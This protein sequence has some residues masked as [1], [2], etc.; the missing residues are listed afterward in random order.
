MLRRLTTFIALLAA[1]VPQAVV[2][3][4]FCTAVGPSFAERRAECDALVVGEAGGEAGG[5][6]R[7]LVHQVWK[8]ADAFAVGT[9]IETDTKNDVATGSTALLIGRHGDAWTWDVL[10]V[11]ESSLAY[12]ARLPTLDRPLADRLRYCAK[13]LESD[14]PRV[15]D[16]AYREFGR[17]PLDAVALTSDAFDYAQVREWLVDPAVPDERKGLY[18]LALGMAAD[19]A[20]RAENVA[21]LKQIVAEP[22][23]DFRSGFDGILGGL[24]WAEGPAGLDL[25]DRQLLANRQAPEGDVRHAQTALRFYQQY[26]H[27]I[28][29]ERMKRSLALLLDRPSTAAGALQD[30]TRRRDWDFVDRAARIFVESPGDDV[31]LDRAVVGY[32]LVSPRPEAAAALKRLRETAGRRVEEAERY[33]ALIGVGGNS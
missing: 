3:C 16:D 28:P 12:F 20:T 13:F 23:S 14:D 19:A 26:G 8:G 31:T 21:L 11:D 4:P 2:A 15:A 25:I 24:L 17:A 29:A 27:D 32:L 10:P 33:L 6:G 7:F 1:L 9:C 5:E 22:K 18:G 30:F